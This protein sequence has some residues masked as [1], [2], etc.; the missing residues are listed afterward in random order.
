MTYRYTV[1]AVTENVQSVTRS[2]HHSHAGNGHFAFTFVSS[3]FDRASR[4]TSF[5]LRMAP[6]LHWRPIALGKPLSA[7]FERHIQLEESALAPF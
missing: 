7:E 3:F 2:W 1:K 4:C 5:F 6:S